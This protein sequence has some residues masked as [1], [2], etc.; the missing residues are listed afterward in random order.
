MFKIRLISDLD[1]LKLINNNH[2]F[3]HRGSIII[4][5]LINFNK[6]KKENIEDADRKIANE[7]YFSDIDH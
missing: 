7:I 2:V 6:F 3:V 4:N 5:D 1:I